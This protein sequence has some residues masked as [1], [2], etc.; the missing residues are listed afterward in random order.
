MYFNRRKIVGD[1]KGETSLTVTA[2]CLPAG[3]RNLVGPYAE[4]KPDVTLIFTDDLLITL[5]LCY[6]WLGGHTAAAA[7]E[8]Q[9]GS[10]ATICL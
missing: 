10:F 6:S 9:S 3:R 8:G 4:T 1:T 5:R 7:G 2:A